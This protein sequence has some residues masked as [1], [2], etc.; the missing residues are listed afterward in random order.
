MAPSMLFEEDRDQIASA[1]VLPLGCAQVI[2]Q[3][4][5][6]DR[7]IR[8]TISAT[9][10]ES[11][12]VFELSSVTTSVPFGPPFSSAGS[13][14]FARYH[15]TCLSSQPI[16][17]SLMYYASRGCHGTVKDAGRGRLSSRQYSGAIHA[18]RVPAP[19]RLL[20][21]RSSK[22]RSHDGLRLPRGHFFR[23]RASIFS[24]MATASASAVPSDSGLTVFSRV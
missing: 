16:G 12:P 8:L 1:E 17:T 7:N 15:R 5:V 4:S 6:Q 18:E 21:A 24:W 19:P 3:S 22:A 2:D 13:T 14:P 9:S 20:P 23:R 11:N 10:V